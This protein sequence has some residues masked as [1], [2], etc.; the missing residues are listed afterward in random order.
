MVSACCIIKEKKL[1][2]DF[3]RL[4]LTEGLITLVL[5]VAVYF[6]LPDCMLDPTLVITIALNADLE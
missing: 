6:L 2:R 4:F 1:T 5:G 3:S